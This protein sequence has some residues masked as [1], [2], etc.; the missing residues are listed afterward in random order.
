MTVTSGVREQTRPFPHAR[1]RAHTHRHAHARAPRLSLRHTGGKG[2]TKGEGAGRL[3]EPPPRAMTDAAEAPFSPP[4]PPTRCS[5]RAP[6]THPVSPLPVP[7][8]PD[9]RAFTRPLPR[10]PPGAP[11]ARRTRGTRWPGAG[12]GA[13]GWGPRRP[14]S[15]LLARPPTQS[16]S[17]SAGARQVSAVGG[18]RMSGEEGTEE[19]SPPPDPFRGRTDRRSGPGLWGASRGQPVAGPVLASLPLG[20][21]PRSGGV[22]GQGQC[23]RRA[24]VG[25]VA[26]AWDRR[27]EAGGPLSGAW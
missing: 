16:P 22:L 7:L 11:G 13:R 18:E 23:G 1:A 8:L 17:P 5:R 25:R 19:L 26:Q 20:V 3:E 6:C 21:G 4:T 14:A 10:H 2:Q 27:R 24:G 12:A 9:A 15:G